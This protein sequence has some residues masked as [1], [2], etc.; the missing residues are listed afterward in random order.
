MHHTR[1]SAVGTHLRAVLGVA[2][3][4]RRRR[5]PSPPHPREIGSLVDPA[6]AL[7]HRS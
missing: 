1:R 5:G 3:R 4:T 6:S 2:V 7:N